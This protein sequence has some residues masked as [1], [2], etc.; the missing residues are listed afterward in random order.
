[1]Q[2]HWGNLIIG[3]VI[4]AFVVPMVVRMVKPSQG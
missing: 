4:G 1:M 3:I 2:I